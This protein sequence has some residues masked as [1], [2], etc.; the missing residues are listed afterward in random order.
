MLLP[1]VGVDKFMSVK[2]PL[3]VRHGFTW[4]SRVETGFLKVVDF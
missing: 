1:S 2:I 3:G 4:I